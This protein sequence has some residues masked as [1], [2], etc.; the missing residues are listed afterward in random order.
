MK[1]LAGRDFEDILL[2]S[3]F[4]WLPPDLIPTY[5]IPSSVGFQSLRV[6]CLMSKI[7]SSSISPLTW[8]HGTHME[9]SACT[10]LT[11]SNPFG[12]KRRNSAVN[13]VVMSTRSVLS[14]RQSDCRERKLP[15]IAAKPQRRGRP[16]L[17]LNSRVRQPRDLNLATTRTSNCSTS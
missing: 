10:P 6:C 13:S 14:T 3:T 9:N 5:D 7:R 4:S 2:V 1:K 11:R 12:R 16:L 17:P 15:L 8:P